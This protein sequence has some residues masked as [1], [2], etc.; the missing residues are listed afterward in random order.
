LSRFIDFFRGRSFAELISKSYR[1]LRRED[2]RGLERLL[3]NIWHAGI[4]YSRSIRQVASIIRR[5]VS[6]CRRGFQA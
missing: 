3:S 6:A 5:P 2:Y 4:S 1:L